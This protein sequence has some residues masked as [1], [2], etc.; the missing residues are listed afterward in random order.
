[1][2]L[3]KIIVAAALGLCLQPAMAD[4][5]RGKLYSVAAA[6]SSE[7]GSFALLMVNPNSEGYFDWDKDGNDPENTGYDVKCGVPYVGWPVLIDLSTDIGKQAMALAASANATGQS[8]MVNYTVDPNSTTFACSL[9][10]L[11][12]YGDETGL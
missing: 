2:S 3:K 12:V 4:Q 1:M 7:L 5:I 10:F 6:P 9:N 11:L 8:V